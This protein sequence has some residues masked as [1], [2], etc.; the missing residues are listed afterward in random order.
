MRRLLLAVG[1][2]A[3]SAWGVVHEL[4]EGEAQAETQPVRPRQVQSVSLDGGFRL[5]DAALR[6]VLT[7]RAGDQ[8]DEAK[9]A[10]DR[11]AMQ[12]V[13]AAR[14]YLAASVGAAQ[15]TFDEAGAAFVT[16]P[17]A[18]GPVFHVRSVQVMGA[19]PKDAGVVTL[20][21][22]EVVSPA[23]IAEA[24]DALADRLTARGKHGSVTVQTTTDAAAA[25][26]DV[27]L[28]AQR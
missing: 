9:L 8:L 23:R 15:V 11:V 6:D 18:I 20:S 24:R 1:L 17:V 28:T 10:H 3:A 26:V 13:L 4:P 7:T 25:A 21:A 16:F 22:G 2:V 19:A 12:D 14:G 27:V 5:P